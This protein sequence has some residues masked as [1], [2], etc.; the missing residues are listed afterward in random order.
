MDRSE[1]SGEVH[2]VKTS[3]TN[4][5]SGQRLRK[6]DGQHRAPV[7]PSLAVSHQDRVGGQL[8]IFNPQSQRLDHAKSRSVQDLADHA[9]HT[10]QPFQNPHDLISREDQVTYA[11]SVRI[12]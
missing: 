1:P 3:H 11:S 6:G 10:I 5:M 4:E 12:E 9:L 7:F 8:D 2:I